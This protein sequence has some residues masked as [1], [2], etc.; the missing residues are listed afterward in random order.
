MFKKDKAH[1]EL[2]FNRNESFIN[3]F[4][5]N[6]G[7][8]PIPPYIKSD[9]N[10]KEDEKN[11]QSIFSKKIGAYASPTAIFHFDANLL[12]NIK[13]KKIDNW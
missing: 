1:V 12:K 8:L 6:F 9:H 2:F 5:I 4:L 3:K 13:K 7:A 11:Y 10:K